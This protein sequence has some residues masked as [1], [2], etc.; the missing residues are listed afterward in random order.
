[1]KAL[2]IGGAFTGEWRDVLDGAGAWVDLV[3][4]ATHRVGY[5]PWVVNAPGEDGVPVV[6]ERY[7][8]P[9][10]VHPDIAGHPAQMQICQQFISNWGITELMREHAINVPVPDSAPDSPAALFG[11]DGKAVGS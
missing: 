5:I 10:L 1:M 6:L 11:P 2:I 4:A 8:L 9:I 7:R 3:S